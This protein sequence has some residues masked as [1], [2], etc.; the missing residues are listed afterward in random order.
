M[1]YFPLYLSTKV[2]RK[3]E[4]FCENILKSI[5]RNIILLT[6]A[7]VNEPKRGVKQEECQSDRMGRTRNP[8][9]GL[10]VPGV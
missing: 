8:L 9:Y 3:E 7:P 5:Q 4:L 10:S 2:E 6:F 1:F